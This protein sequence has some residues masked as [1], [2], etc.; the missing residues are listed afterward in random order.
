LIQ[1]RGIDSVKASL[2]NRL[3][4]KQDE[5]ALMRK[6][7]FLE[8]VDRLQKSSVKKSDFSG[9]LLQKTKTEKWFER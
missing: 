3:E 7:G 4:I 1:H 8:T 2:G 5:L 9:T 6:E